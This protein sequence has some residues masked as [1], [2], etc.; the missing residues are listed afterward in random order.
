MENNNIDN[1]LNKRIESLNINSWCKN[2]IHL[3]NKMGQVLRYI[4]MQ[5][6]EFTVNDVFMYFKSKVSKAT[7]YDALFYL[8]CIE[9]VRV[10]GN[11]KFYKVKL[12]EE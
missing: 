6:D 10:E 1:L 4:V 5:E 12:I 8:N 2:R 11:L 9:I 3:D 7:I